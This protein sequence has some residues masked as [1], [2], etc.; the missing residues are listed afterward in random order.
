[1]RRVFVVSALGLLLVGCIGVP[2]EAPLSPAGDV[3][4]S[5]SRDASEHAPQSGQS[6]ESGADP[7]PFSDLPMA[8][9]PVDVLAEGYQMRF[10]VAVSLPS[11]QR[12]AVQFATLDASRWQFEDAPDTF[13]QRLTR[14]DRARRGPVAQL[15]KAIHLRLHPIYEGFLHSL[16]PE[17]WGGDPNLRT[18]LG[19]EVATKTGDLLQLGVVQSSGEELFDMAA[20]ESLLRAFPIEVPESA[21]NLPERMFLTWEMHRISHFSCSTFFVRSYFFRPTAEAGGEPSGR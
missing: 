19:L 15:L 8:P 1:M 2:A 9:L 20:L 16:D 6:S 11:E 4:E 21:R 17:A 18:V 10:A 5:S 3:A 13:S 14:V 7:V 12:D